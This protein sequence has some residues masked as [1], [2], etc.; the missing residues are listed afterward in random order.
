MHSSNGILPSW[1][2]IAFFIKLFRFLI[3]NLF[4]FFTNKCLFLTN[5]FVFL[6]NIF[7]FLTNI[8]V[9]LTNIFVCLINIFVFMA[10]VFVVVTDIFV[11][12]IIMVILAN[13]YYT[14][15]LNIHLIIGP[16]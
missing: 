14:K 12:P 8:F 3:D 7:V 5:I 13:L 6:K 16:F 4:V 10:R 9:F 11:F 1:E 15:L 2:E